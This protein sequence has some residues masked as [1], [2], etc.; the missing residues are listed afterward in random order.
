[1]LDLDLWSAGARGRDGSGGGAGSRS[2]GGRFGQRVDVWLLLE[3]GVRLIIVSRI[4]LLFYPLLLTIASILNIFSAISLLY[5][6]V[7]VE[8]TLGPRPATHQQACCHWRSKSRTTLISKTCMY[9]SSIHVPVAPVESKAASKRSFPPL[10]EMIQN[11]TS[12]ASLGKAAAEPCVA[13]GQGNCWASVPEHMLMTRRVAKMCVMGNA[14]TC[15]A[16]K[17]SRQFSINKMD[18]HGP[19]DSA[20][21]QMMIM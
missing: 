17:I 9:R 19:R 20:V 18:R 3:V 8:V 13:S 6:V 5:R 14:A 21:S 7:A 2:R 4:S 16:A 11:Q 12:V 15:Q 10:K 1:M